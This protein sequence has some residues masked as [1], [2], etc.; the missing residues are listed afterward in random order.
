MIARMPYDTN[1]YHNYLPTTAVKTKLLKN[2]F[3]LRGIILYTLVN[4]CY[5]FPGKTV[6]GVLNHMKQWRKGS[7]DF[8]S[9][10]STGKYSLIR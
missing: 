7:M 2:C 10:V 4:G 9:D 1:I 3:C 8:A 6:K 5:P